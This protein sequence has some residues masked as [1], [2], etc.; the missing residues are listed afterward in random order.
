MKKFQTNSDKHVRTLH[1][2]DLH[3]LSTN[4]SIGSQRS[5]IYKNQ[6]IQY[7][8]TN[9]RKFKSQYSSIEVSSHTAS[10]ISLLLCTR[11]LLKLTLWMAL[12]TCQAKTMSFAITLYI[13]TKILLSHPSAW[14]LSQGALSYMKSLHPLGIQCRGKPAAQCNIFHVTISKCWSPASKQALILQKIFL[15]TWRGSCL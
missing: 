6:V 11:I 13:N 9:H 7:L 15:S 8:S 3:L 10:I 14:Q 5:L 2:L 4:L 1:R 12:K